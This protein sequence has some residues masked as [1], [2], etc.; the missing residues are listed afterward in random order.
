MN[1]D[2]FGVA[3]LPEFKSK[4]PVT[5]LGEYRKDQ[6]KHDFSRKQVWF[7]V[8]GEDGLEKEFRTE[9]EDVVNSRF[10]DDEIHWDMMTLYPTHA[11]GEVNRNMRRLIEAVSSDTGIKYEQVLERT[12]KTK[13]NHELDSKRAKAVNLRGSIDVKDFDGGNVIL[14]DNISLSGTS[15]AHGASKLKEAGA[16][17][18]FGVVLGLAE[19]FPGKRREGRSKTA[20]RL[21]KEELGGF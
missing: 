3:D 4:V 14:F 11:K 12:K 5:A 2:Y 16:E 7:Y 15:M 17:N 20:S 10:V 21:I 1:K 19:D 8:Y 13:E 9:L 18:V 6:G